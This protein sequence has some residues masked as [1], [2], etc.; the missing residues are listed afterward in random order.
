[1]FSIISLPQT[2]EHHPFWHLKLFSHLCS[3]DMHTPIALLISLSA[4]QCLGFAAPEPLV[5]RGK[6][7]D[8][9]VLTGRSET[10]VVTDMLAI[11]AITANVTTTTCL[12]DV[13]A[14]PSHLEDWS[15]NSSSAPE[16]S[17][18]TPCASPECAS[19]TLIDSSG[20]TSAS[21]SLSAPVSVSASQPEA[22]FF[23][24]PLAPT[25]THTAIESDAYIGTC[26]KKSS[27]TPWSPR[28]DAP[29]VHCQGCTLKVNSTTTNSCAPSSTHNQTSTLHHGPIPTTR[30]ET[31]PSNA[32]I[33]LLHAEKPALCLALLT[34]LLWS[35]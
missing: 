5:M 35:P 19:A 24:C 18:T 33:S 9:Q 15:D 3:L 6:S 14:T 1:M 28:P 23:P 20:L 8:L 25:V 17:S 7:S 34:C 2:L 4:I 11:R 30:I 29:P 32:A 16:L 21:I 13:P 31:M 12:E 22:D 10:T 27:H 26:L